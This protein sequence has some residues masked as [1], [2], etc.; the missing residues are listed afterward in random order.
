M[1][2]DCYSIS[3]LP[4]L[5]K[6]FADYAASFEPLK[7]FYAAAPYGPVAARPQSDAE[8]YAP[9]ADLLEEQKY[10]VAAGVSLAFG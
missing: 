8:R 7:P 5:S 2:T 9:I 4:R 10:L 6:L 1:Q 3:I